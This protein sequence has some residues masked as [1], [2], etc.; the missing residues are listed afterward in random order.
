M[1]WR[2]PIS[3]LASSYGTFKTALYQMSKVHSIHTVSAPV[4]LYISHCINDPCK[5]T[6][7]LNGR[8]GV[9]VECTAMFGSLVPNQT[10]SGFRSDLALTALTASRFQEQ[11]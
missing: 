9:Q 2:G 1:C 6:V 10:N 7:L 5:D 4:H 8:F 3:G 11:R